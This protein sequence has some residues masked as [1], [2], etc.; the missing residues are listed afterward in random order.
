MTLSHQEALD[1]LNTKYTLFPGWEK[2]MY[3]YSKDNY[4]VFMNMNERCYRYYFESD[5]LVRSTLQQNKIMEE[6]DMYPFA[7]GCT[8][9]R[10]QYMNTDGVKIIAH[11]LLPQSL[12]KF[13]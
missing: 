11:H 13:L 6:L 3:V 4:Y 1:I 7:P 9:Q 10:T 12:K 5:R 8:Y 2:W